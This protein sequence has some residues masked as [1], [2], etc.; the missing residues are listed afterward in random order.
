MQTNNY[1]IACTYYYETDSLWKKSIVL[2]HCERL[3]R[4]FCDLLINIS[5]SHFHYCFD[6][7]SLSRLDPSLS[8]CSHT[9]R[10][11]KFAEEMN[12]IP[13][14]RCAQRG[15]WIPANPSTT[16]FVRRYK[17][18]VLTICIVWSRSC[19]VRA[20]DDAMSESENQT[21]KKSRTWMNGNK[22]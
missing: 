12:L 2:G 9:G 19:D 17:R 3:H 20:D 10:S 16:E 6:R 5:S 14:M 7:C 4:D 18:C 8:L 21:I 11:M 15:N 1:I 13:P 22:M